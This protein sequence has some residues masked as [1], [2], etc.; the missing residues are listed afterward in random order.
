MAKQP[1]RLPTKQEILDFIQNSDAPVGKRE[2]ARAFQVKGA[3]R[4][5]L[6]QLL[7]ELE[8]EG[9]IDRG[10]KR[11]M[12]PKGA[13]PE[14]VVLQV[15]DYDDD[16]D[17]IARPTGPHEE[18]AARIVVVPGGRRQERVKP[19]D[20]VLARLRRLGADSYEAQVIRVLTSGPD[21]VLGVVAGT[22]RNR[23]ANSVDRRLD[24]SYRLIDAPEDIREGDLVLIRPL[25]TRRGDREAEVA[26]KIGSMAEPKAF[27]LIAIHQNG[28]PVDFSEAA[29]AEAEAFDEPR[30]TAKRTDLRDLPLVTIDGADARDFDD[31]V[32]AAPDED[33]S[34]PGGFH[35][36]VAIADVSAYVRPQSALDRA[37]RPR[38]NSVYFPD[39]VVPMLP[40]RLSNG[41]CSL[42]PD[43][44]RY[45]IACRMV[46]SKTGA[47][48]SHR[49]ERA[50]MRSA[51]RLTYEQ[52]QS[53]HDG[54]VDDV[55]DTLA[56]PV[57]APLYA[58]FR[59]LLAAREAR[60]T[61]ELDL[62]ERQ[63]LI[64]EDGKV[65]EIHR[66]ARLDSHRLIEE[67]MITANV[68]A[69]ESL[70]KHQARHKLPIMYRVHEPPPLDKLEGLRE[71][72]QVLGYKLAKG[73]V[74]KPALFTG[75][76]AQ[77]ERDGKADIVSD[78]ILRS[79]AQAYYSASNLGHFGLA[80]RRY[81]HFTSPIRRYS[82][83]MVHRALIS[84]HGL[85]DDGLSEEDIEEFDDTAELI[86]GTERRAVAAERDALERYVTAFMAEHVGS[87][88]DA[89]IS[90]VARF[91]L[92]V[93]LLETGAEGL[94]PVSTLD[95]D[96]YEHDEVHQCL[97]GRSNSIAYTLS[98]RVRVRL[99]EA[100]E[101][102]GGLLFE[103]V[104]GG[105]PAPKGAGR[106]G[107]KRGKTGPSRRG[108]PRGKKAS[109]RR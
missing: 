107:K 73:A 26:E 75:I 103:M 8:A 90:G 35:L 33:P 16:G 58:A 5:E 52:V 76:L 97:V 64:G 28:I 40:E 109:R 95:D 87:E 32:H 46:I 22:G 84:A 101:T 47:L 10:R 6:R 63:V 54:R 71:S 62:P 86:S 79:Q 3:M 42:R 39:R 99:K 85:G 106:G 30:M 27:S 23:T 45:C 34:N 92:F 4:T 48:L 104:E 17:L 78:I 81:C 69:A 91:G 51:A 57:I 65:A 31:A 83:L 7:K 29:L 9:A 25:P 61:L 18:S 49:F 74:I 59:A 19:G 96:Y 36:T 21:K 72:L 60:G 102:T 98:D 80:L 12:A 41:L 24:R 68:A 1:A 53:A 70:E 13:L 100:N 55:T 2:I 105:R 44:D 43:E 66:R 11:R 15:G 38:G 82:D 89:R 14:V 50:I 56:G 94:I 20:R 37:A 108:P 77:A 88:F 67:F 93:S